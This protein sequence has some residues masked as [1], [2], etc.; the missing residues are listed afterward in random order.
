[1]GMIMNRCK[2][3][4]KPR[5]MEW[6]G[7]HNGGATFVGAAGVPALTA[8]RKRVSTSRPVAAKGERVCDKDQLIG[9]D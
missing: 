1:M 4:R 3:T 8:L 2:D 5:V 7:A 6:N 9:L